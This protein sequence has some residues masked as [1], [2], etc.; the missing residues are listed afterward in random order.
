MPKLSDLL[1]NKVDTKIWKAEKDAYL[2]L[3]CIVS[4]SWLMQAVSSQIADM[5]PR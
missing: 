5:G 4:Q 1:L 2:A 3:G